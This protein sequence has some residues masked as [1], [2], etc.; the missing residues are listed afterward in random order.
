[1]W[2]LFQAKPLGDKCKQYPT[3]LPDTNGVREF[4]PQ[5]AC[6]AGVTSSPAVSCL[7]RRQ[8]LLEEINEYFADLV[9]SAILKPG[10]SGTGM[11]YSC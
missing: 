11:V 7:L 5:A 4:F 6:N 9:P 3:S 2:Q 1:M 10:P 8:A